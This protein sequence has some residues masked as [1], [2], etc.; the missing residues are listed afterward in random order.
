MFAKWE[1]LWDNDISLQLNSMGL[2]G[3]QE[4]NFTLM[5]MKSYN[6]DSN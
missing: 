4:G 5:F 6:L 1:T 2:L 3:L